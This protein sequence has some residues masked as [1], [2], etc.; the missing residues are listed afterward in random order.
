MRF[1]PCSRMGV[2]RCPP[3][4]PRASGL[5]VAQL[6]QKDRARSV[7]LRGVGHFEVKFLVEGLR[8][9]QHLYEA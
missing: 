9:A 4:S 7:I 1:V 3:T 8:F 5:Q 6:W 2:R